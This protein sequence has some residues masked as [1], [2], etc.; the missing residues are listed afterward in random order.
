MHQEVSRLN[1]NYPNPELWLRL[2]QQPLALGA[3]LAL[4]LHA[5]A[6]PLLLSPLPAAPSRTAASRNEPLPQLLRL[7]RTLQQRRQLKP[8]ALAL[9]PLALLDNLPPP[10]PPPPPLPSQAAAA[11]P[12]AAPL[13]R[14]SQADAELPG[15][16]WQALRL[17]LAWVPGASLALDRQQATALEVRR[18]QLWLTPGQ[19]QQMERIWQQ[20]QPASL[21]GDAWSGS[22]VRRL[23]AAGLIAMGLP[24]PHGFSLVTDDHLWLGWRKGAQLVLIRAPLPSDSGPKG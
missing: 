20:A 22:A 1:W 2:R 17:S 13:W 18:R 16:P 14:W 10:P 24:D 6:L 23:P 7:G 11:A 21:P 12:A 4:G 5:L 15:D 8:S 9:P 3:L 19:A